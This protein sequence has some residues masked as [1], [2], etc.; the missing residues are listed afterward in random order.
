MERPS[1][2]GFQESRGLGVLSVAVGIVISVSAF[3]NAAG[4]FSR[5]SGV[6]LAG[7]GGCLFVSSAM[8][9]RLLLSSSPNSGAERD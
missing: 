3:A 5:S 4:L 7:V 1:E 2:L 9:S 8:F 6:Y